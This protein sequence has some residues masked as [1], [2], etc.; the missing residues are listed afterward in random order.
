MPRKKHIRKVSQRKQGKPPFYNLLLLLSTLLL[1]DGFLRVIFSIFPYTG[2][3]MHYVR[4][5]QTRWLL[6]GI[7]EL[8]CAYGLIRLKKWALFV[9]FALSLF[10]V[11][12]ILVYLPQG[13]F[14]PVQNNTLFYI[15]KI[16][17]VI[18]LF[19]LF[20]KRKFFT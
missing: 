10:R 14:P 1:I 6:I 2:V 12:T 9:L 15:S 11:Y 20:T 5:F 8:V 3:Y 19:Y 4:T 13:P 7:T 18:I 16:V 17:T